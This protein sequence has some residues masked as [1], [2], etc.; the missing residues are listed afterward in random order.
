ME[1]LYIEKQKNKR[2]GHVI[3]VYP[4]AVYTLRVEKRE[5]PNYF[6]ILV[7]TNEDKNHFNFQTSFATF[8]NQPTK[9]GFEKHCQYCYDHAPLYTDESEDADIRLHRPERS[10]R[11]RFTIYA[12][13]ESALVPIHQEE[14]LDLPPTIPPPAWDPAAIRRVGGGGGNA[15]E[16]GRIISGH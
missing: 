13:F 1:L 3:N 10:Q 4:L 8:N 16:L 2:D 7:L 15:K 9:L 14:N 5:L 6:G 11:S 12:E